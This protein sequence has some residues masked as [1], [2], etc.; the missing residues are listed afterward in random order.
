MLYLRTLSS[1]MPSRGRQRAGGLP[2]DRSGVKLGAAS[3]QPMKTQIFLLAG[4]L[5]LTAGAQPSVVTIIQTEDDQTEAVSVGANEAVEIL[6]AFDFYGAGSSLAFKKGKARFDVIPGNA[7][8]GLPHCTPHPFVL[9]GPA[10][11]AVHSGNTQGARTTNT[12]V[13]VTL[14]IRRTR[15]AASTPAPAKATSQ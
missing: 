14:E 9:A 13:V 6:A 5:T 4:I 12:P 1:V 10:E 15:P 3:F 11:L 7:A 2:S 8:G